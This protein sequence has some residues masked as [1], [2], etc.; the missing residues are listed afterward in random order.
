MFKL[1]T[2]RIVSCAIMVG[3]LFAIFCGAGVSSTGVV[4]NSGTEANRRAAPGVQIAFSP[5]FALIGFS[6][7]TLCAW[8]FRPAKGT[9]DLPGL[10]A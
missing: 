9:T 5:T 10:P 1:L 8:Q 2:P 6:L 4:S 7:G 3:V